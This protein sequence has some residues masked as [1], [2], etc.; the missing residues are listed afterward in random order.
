MAK[1]H[2]GLYAIPSLRDRTGTKHFETKTLC[3]IMK[4]FYHELYFSEGQ[5]TSENRKLFLDRINLPTLSEERKNDLCRPITVQEVLEIIKTLQS[6]KAPGPDGFGPKFYKK[7]AKSVVGPVTNMFIESFERGTLPPTLNL[8]H[9]PLISK[10]DKPSDQC[11]SYRPISLLGV[12]CKLLSK[13]LARRLKEVLPVL[14]KPDQTGF[15]KNRYSYSNVRRLL[16]L[17][18]FAHSTKK[19]VLSASLDAKKKH[20][21]T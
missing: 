15:V 9:I 18:Q 19:K 16:N 13:L 7:M 10:K 8:A 4:D 12:D 20:L 11:A 14:V 5:I 2:T 21:I 6:G 3:K 1:G 17:I